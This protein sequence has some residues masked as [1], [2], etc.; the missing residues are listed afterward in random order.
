[1]AAA[2]K[3]SGSSGIFWMNGGSDEEH[4]LVFAP[5]VDG[6][7]KT[8]TPFNLGQGSTSTSNKRGSKM[9][10]KSASDC[11]NQ[12]TQK[13]RGKMQ[14]HSQSA[15]SGSYIKEKV[16]ACHTAA[17]TAEQTISPPSGTFLPLSQVICDTSRAKSEVCLKDLCPEDKRRIANLI[18]ELARVSEEKEESVQRLKDEQGNFERKI[19]QLEQQNL[20]IAQERESLQQQ[21][22]ECQELLGLYQQYLSQQQAKLNQSIAQ[23]TQPPTHSKVLSSEEAPSRTSTSRANGS[24]FDGSYLSLAATGPQPPQVY[25]SGDGR[26]RTVR[27]FRNP[28]S[29]SCVDEL[30]LAGGPIKQ[31]MSQNWECREPHSCHKCEHCQCSGH[32]TG[33]GTQQWRSNNISH[34]VNGHHDNFTQEAC[35]RLQS[36][37]TM[38]SEAKEALSRPLLGHED[39]EEKR[40]QLLLQKIQ[41]EMERERLQARLT[42]Q[43]ERLNRQN[44]Q[45]RQSRL[46][47]SRFKQATQAEVSSSNIRNGDTEPQGSTYQDLPSSVREDAEAHPAGQNLHEKHSQTVPAPVDAGDD[48][49]KRSRRDMATSP[50]KSPAGLNKPTSASVIPKTPEARSDFSVVEL[51]DI[52]SPVSAREQCKPTMRRPK[53]SQHRSALAAP[54]SVG[55]TLLSSGL[56]YPQSTQQ[57]LEESQ[58]LEDIFFIC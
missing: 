30:S 15:L 16:S 24:L 27:A 50:T 46:D 39:W 9:Q 31:Q 42:E 34:L 57:D 8:R 5:G 17:V 14:G 18:E 11:K 7:V 48:P 3:R 19:Q 26:E 58:I 4:P 22:R 13:R 29:L 32:D 41:L 54:T 52:F 36:E 12:V 10:I 45:L 20:M 21:Y 49:L 33:Y 6:E 2:A 55:R 43:E 25:R 51:L 47:Y 28:A 53:T 1:M 56:A 23:L 35:E 40:H 37:N 38:C 44:Q